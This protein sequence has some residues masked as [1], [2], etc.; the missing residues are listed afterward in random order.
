MIR[1]KVARKRAQRITRIALAAL[2]ELGFKP[3]P[4]LHERQYGGGLGRVK[5]PGRETGANPLLRRS[6]AEGEIRMENCWVREHSA[7]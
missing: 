4:E 1:N 5:A 6:D 2:S 7:Q 3:L